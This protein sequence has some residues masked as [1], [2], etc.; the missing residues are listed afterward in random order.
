MKINFQPLVYLNKLRKDNNYSVIIRIG[1]ESKYA[2]I[3]TGIFA[4]KTELKK[5]STNKRIGEIGNATI[6]DICNKKIEEYKK[7]IREAQ[8]PENDGVLPYNCTVQDIKA[9]LLK[10]TVRPDSLDFMKLFK[11][12]IDE[13]TNSPSIRIYEAAYNHLQAFAGTSLLVDDITPNKLK[14]FEKH[15]ASTITQRGTPMGS[16]G[17]NLYLSQIR[18]VYNWIMDEHEY[19]GYS[20]RYPF[21]KYEIPKAT[22]PKTK[23]LTKEQLR[24][25][26][27]TPLTGIRANRARDLFVISL[28]SLGTNAKDLYL[29]DSIGKRIEYKRSK[30]KGKREDEAFISIAVQPE[31]KPYINKYWTKICTR[32]FAQMYASPEQLNKA[33][34]YGMKQVIKQVN[35]IYGEGFLWD[36]DYYDARRSMASIMSNDLELSNDD[37]SRCL[38]HVDSRNVMLRPYVERKF[39]IVDKCN[40]KFID[41]LF[42]ESASDDQH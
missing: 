26:I 4:G 24:A 16:R 2:N 13:N 3:D 5:R 41:W 21:R 11:Q 14:E 10:G 34:L 37:V 15:L 35:Q 38:N 28:L 40:R 12:F 30:T 6:L 19:K 18:T 39:D 17:V 23:A 1:Y 22:Y 7:L 31:L 8:L 25:I 20:F 29:L 42:S 9:L 27:E 32:P 33:I 36:V